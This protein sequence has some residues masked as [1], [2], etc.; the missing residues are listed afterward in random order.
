LKKIQRGWYNISKDLKLKLA[1]R[2]LDK[3][4]DYSRGTMYGDVH[5]KRLSRLVGHIE[6]TPTQNGYVVVTTDKSVEDAVSD[7]W[8][9]VRN[10]MEKWNLLLLD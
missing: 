1:S 5:T 3:Y 7:N 2:F 8:L 4:Y 10:Y 6:H 9:K